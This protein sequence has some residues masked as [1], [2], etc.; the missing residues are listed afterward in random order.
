MAE[1]YGILIGTENAL[2][3]HQNLIL[4][5]LVDHPLFRFYFDNQNLWRMKGQSCQEVL[6]VMKEHLIEVHVKDSLMLDGNQIWMPLGQGDCEFTSSMTS[7]KEF[8]YQG[9]IHLE[10]DYQIDPTNDTSYSY[11]DA[12]QKDLNTLKAI[13]A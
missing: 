11:T 2:G 4:A 13:F 9:W 1:A 12:I 7:L 8:D 5:Q 3:K 6:S 10:N